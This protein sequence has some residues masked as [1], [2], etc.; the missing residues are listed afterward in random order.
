M[1]PGTSEMRNPASID[2]QVSARANRNAVIALNCTGPGG[3]KFPEHLPV[4]PLA[5][6]GFRHSSSSAG[7]ARRPRARNWHSANATLK[8]DMTDLHPPIAPKKHRE[9]QVHGHTL[10]DDYAWLR[11]KENPE[12]I[13]YL[14]AENKYAEAVMAPL[15]GLQ[16]QIYNEM[17]SHIKQTDVSVPFR[18]GSWWYYTRTEEKLQY[19][20]HCRK[21]GGVDGPGTDAPEQIILD[22][23]KLAEGHSFFSIGATD[24]TDDGRWLAYTTDITGFRQSTLHFKDLE[25]GE[26]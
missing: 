9:I 3:E 22:G 8:N 17:L 13:A 2:R 6:G 25:T 18:D 12:V 26:T 4:G 5:C 14:E 15:A 10:V 20:I 23:N 21:L 11:D 7:V 1:S 19:S 24:I 16:E